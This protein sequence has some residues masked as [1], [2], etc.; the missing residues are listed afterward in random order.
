MHARARGSFSLSLISSFLCSF[1]SSVH[2]HDRVSLRAGARNCERGSASKTKRARARM[3]SEIPGCSLSLS[4]SRECTG[5]FLAVFPPQCCRSL[6]LRLLLA[7]S[8]GFRESE[9]SECNRERE[10][11]RFGP[12]YAEG[13]LRAESID[14]VVDILL[15]EVVIVFCLRIMMMM[16]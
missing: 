11:E 8:R 4:F 16:P 9:L 12:T 6:L 15:A 10:R 13:Y 3:Q 2:A 5:Y 14:I 7:F 1:F